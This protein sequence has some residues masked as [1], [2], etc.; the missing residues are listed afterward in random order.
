MLEAVI[1]NKFNKQT[2]EVQMGIQMLGKVSVVEKST[3][4]KIK[5][6]LTPYEVQ[7][8]I[9]QRRNLK[10]IE[11]MQKVEILKPFL[12]QLRSLIDKRDLDGLT[13]FYIKWATQVGFK[14]QKAVDI[15]EHKLFDKNQMYNRWVTFAKVV[16]NMYLEL[17]DDCSKKQRGIKF[18]QTKYQFEKTPESNDSYDNICRI[19]VEI[20]NFVNN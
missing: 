18:K 16:Y 6:E 8:K 20:D 5:E 1:N 2:Q 10:H 3:G 17:F 7:F 9:E 13:N 19:L 14:N 11:N 4:R 12:N 15:I